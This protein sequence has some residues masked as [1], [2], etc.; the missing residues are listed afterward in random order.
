MPTADYYTLLTTYQISSTTSDTHAN[1][2]ADGADADDAS[3]PTTINDDDPA[4]ATTTV[5]P[6]TTTK[7]N[8]TTN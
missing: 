5:S 3:N 1:I 8:T 7:P 2:P 4:D 6:A